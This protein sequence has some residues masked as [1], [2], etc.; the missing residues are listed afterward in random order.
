VKN[1]TVLTGLAKAGGPAV[2]CSAHIG[3]WEF[4]QAA[5]AACGTPFAGVYR[6]AAD[7]RID[8]LIQ[9]MRTASVRP[10]Q[11]FFPKGSAGARQAIKH[12]ASGG[13]LA[14]LVDQKMNDGIEARFFGMPAMTAPAAAAFALRLRCP[15]ICGRVER[16][17]PARLR[18]V[19]EDPLELPDS[20]DR[21]ADILALTQRINDVLEG[22]IRE[23]PDSWLWLHRRWPKDIVST[24]QR[25]KRPA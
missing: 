12:I 11:P 18:V 9:G 22:W 21:Q 2:F 1:E 17:G 7:S 19:V 8:A 4:L 16:L 20:G 24:K 23:A 14:L 6:A 3:N 15:V 5:A 10:S 25:R 13:R